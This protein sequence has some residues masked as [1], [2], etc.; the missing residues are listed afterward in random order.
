MTGEVM[1]R[2]NCYSVRISHNQDSRIVYIF[3]AGKLGSVMET[4][5]K[6]DAWGFEQP[7]DNSNHMIFFDMW[8]PFPSDLESL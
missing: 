7:G 2:E 8:S 3:L 6:E 4:E 5:V 1:R